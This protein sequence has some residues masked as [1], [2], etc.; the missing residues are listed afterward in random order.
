MNPVLENESGDSSGY[1][2]GTGSIGGWEYSQMRSWLK[3]SVKP[4]IPE[5]VRNTIKPVTKYSFSRDSS[6]TSVNNVKTTEDV[7]IPS[8]REICGSATHQETE[9]PSYTDFFNDHVR[10]KMGTSLAWWLRTSCYISSFYSVYSDGS[11]GYS[12][13]TSPGGVVLGFCI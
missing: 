4:M 5:T 2:P 7:W 11:V 1:R 13:A 9:G 8:V 10:Q 12:Y 3:E 6:N